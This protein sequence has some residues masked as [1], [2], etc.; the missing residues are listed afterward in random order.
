MPKVR[1][2]VLGCGDVAQRDYLP[3]LHR[4]VD[5]AELVAVC[6]R[7][8]ARARAVAEQYGV[9]A[10]FTAH[11]R[12][13]AECE[14][15]AVANLTPIQ[16]HAG[17]NLALL[18]AGKHVYTEKP[19]T[20]TVRDAER[21]RSAARERG[22]K[23]VCAPCVMLFPQVCHA[24]ALLA[25]GVVGP[26]YSASAYGHG[27]VPP[28]GG[29]PSDPS[30]FFAPGGGPAFDM[31]VYPLHALTG[32]LGPARHVTAMASR[33]QDRFTIADGP[34]QGKQV[35]IEVE[36]N[37]HLLLDF[38]GGR[39]ASVQANN[40][41]Q[42]ARAPQM[43]LFGLAGTIALDILD[44]SAPVHLLRA[45]EG[46]QTIDLPRT[47]RARGPDHLLGIEHLVDCIQHDREPVLSIDHAL[48]VIEILEKAA[49]AAQTGRTHVIESV[50]RQ[51]G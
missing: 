24:R 12:M 13:L 30:P 7:T 41:V 9:S 46:W 38:G 29:Y 23:L 21:L 2:A 48:H 26:V 14:I 50:F 34:L 44:V 11:E 18:E 35:R 6:N 39:L 28:W 49:I 47:G 25:D 4:L 1:L 43:E 36:D 42:G 40:C 19:A 8:E 32:L 10:W 31:G 3:E 20:S 27:G 37:W 16:L 15:D 5:R 33:A 22:R 17:L 51:H 45:G